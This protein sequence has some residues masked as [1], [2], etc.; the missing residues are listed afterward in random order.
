MTKREVELE[1]QPAEELKQSASGSEVLEEIVDDGKMSAQEYAVM[2]LSKVLRLRG[3]RIERAD[4]LRQELRK[5]GL[6][7][8]QID[9][10]VSTTPIQ[11]GVLLEQLDE[12]AQ[13]TIAFESRKSAAMSFAAGLPGGFALFASIP[14]DLVQYYAHAFRVMQKLAYLYGWQEFLSDI[15]DVDD[16]TLGLLTAFLG[17]MMGVGG[18]SNSVVAFAQRV[19]QP[20]V[21]RQIVKQA[22]T[23]TWW[24]LPLKG[25]LKRVGVSITKQSLGKAVSKVVPV[26]GGAISGGMTLVSLGREAKRLQKHLRELPP[27]GSD[28]AAY[29]AATCLGDDGSDL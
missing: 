8:L 22:L 21:E 6:S 9:R 29:R 3:V 20:A 26:A 18:A 11:A 4:Y 2:F 7:D 19:A 23:K 16:E 28:A 13:K 27:P 15:D 17:V 24:Y 14:G 10:A 5:L 12:L 25:T 1:V